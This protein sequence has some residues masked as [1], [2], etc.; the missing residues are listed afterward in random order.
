MDTTTDRR[1]I[2]KGA[3]LGA[4]LAVPGA[5]LAADPALRRAVAAGHDEPEK[6]AK[7]LRR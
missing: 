1:T 5:G 7:L 3:A 4:A 2:L 6:L